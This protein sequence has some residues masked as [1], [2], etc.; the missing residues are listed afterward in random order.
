MVWLEQYEDAWPLEAALT[1]RGANRNRHR[2]SVSEPTPD[3]VTQDVKEEQV[4]DSYLIQI[5]I[6][7]LIS[8]N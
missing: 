4:R 8:G 3:A 7:N 1:I 2:T 5:N 6:L